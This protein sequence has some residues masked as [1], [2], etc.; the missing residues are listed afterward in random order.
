MDSILGG[1]CKMYL[2]DELR[3]RGNVV[4]D[5][6]GSNFITQN[7][8]GYCA[9]D[10]SGGWDYMLYM[11]TSNRTVLGY[12]A[13]RYIVCFGHFVPYNHRSYWLGTNSPAQQWKGVC[14]EGGTV[15]SSDARLKENIQRLSGEAV[16]VSDEGNLQEIMLIDG[17]FDKAAPSDYYEF[18]RDRFK[19]TYF[20][21]KPSVID[22]EINED[23]QRRMEEDG[24]VPSAPIKIEDE[25][26]LLK[27][28]GFLAQDYDLEN[29]KVAQEFIFEGADGM[30]GYNHMSYAT[31]GMVALQEA[32]K[33]IEQLEKRIEVLEDALEKKLDKP[34][35]V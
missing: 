5:T 2:R 30:L 25:E 8:Y 17:A 6:G 7:N 10:T 23:V 26:K 15:G 35:K 33:K 27:N 24:Y 29:D 31:V 32:I 22:E 3:L 13:A 1:Y 28:V 20:N 14:C 34:K 19:P 11:D 18:M 9:K 12:N 16:N 4:L 21:Y